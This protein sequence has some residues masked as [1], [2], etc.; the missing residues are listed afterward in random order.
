VYRPSVESG[1]IA[2][3]PTSRG[4]FRRLYQRPALVINSQGQPVDFVSQVS[5]LPRV[6]FYPKGSAHRK[7]DIEKL[8]DRFAEAEN[9]IFF[10]SQ[11]LARSSDGREESEAMSVAIRQLWRIKTE[12][13]GW[14]TIDITDAGKS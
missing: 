8:A 2:E 9:A 11:E 1:H 6:C 4:G 10:R 13:L 14:P 5:V 3:A 7:N 12:K